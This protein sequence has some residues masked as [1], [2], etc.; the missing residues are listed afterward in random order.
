MM[1]VMMIMISDQGWCRV[2]RRMRER[3]RVREREREKALPM[4]C[5][6]FSMAVVFFSPEKMKLREGAGQEKSERVPPVRAPSPAEKAWAKEA[7][8]KKKENCLLR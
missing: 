5:V 1:T 4:A 3:E 8:P 7:D 2:G 6:V